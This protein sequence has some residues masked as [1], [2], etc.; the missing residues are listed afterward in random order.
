MWL[1]RFLPST[2]MPVI[3]GRGRLGEED[4]ESTIILGYTENLPAWDMRPYLRGR[5][6]QVP[7]QLGLQR[8]TV[9]KEGRTDGRMDRRT[10][11]GGEEGRE[12]RP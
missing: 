3:P 7:G 10:G 5:P 8:D 11:R 6:K 9:R 12:N 4:Q 1:N 2:D